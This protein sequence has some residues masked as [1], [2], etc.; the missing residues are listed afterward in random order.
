MRTRQILLVGAISALAMSACTPTPEATAP[1]SAVSGSPTRES[2][3]PVHWSSSSVPSSGVQLSSALQRNGSI[4]V[5]LIAGEAVPSTQ[6]EFVVRLKNHSQDPISLSPCPP[7]RVQFSTVVEVGMLNCSAGPNSIP[8]NGYVDFA[9]EVE[10]PAFLRGIDSVPLL[11]QL[12]SE[13][14]EGPTAS[15]GVDIVLDPAELGPIE[16]VRTSTYPEFSPA[17]RVVR[18]RSI[19]V[20]TR[21]SCKPAEDRLEGAVL[22]R[23]GPRTVKTAAEWLIG[24]RSTAIVLAQ[25]PAR[26]VVLELNGNER[27]IGRTTLQNEAG[28][29]YAT[30]GMQ[31]TAAPD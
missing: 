21:L 9:M 2:A 1:S 26:A 5:E 17:P 16:V 6:F 19:A 8:P 10:A 30:G 3:T 29:W 14:D 27:V 15:M 20:D 24:R 13:G 4:G 31:C 23:Q 12:G 28:R 25:S 11:W 22:W 7:Y 18:I